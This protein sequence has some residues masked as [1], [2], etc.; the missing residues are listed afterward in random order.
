VGKG[1]KAAAITGLARH[2]LRAAAQYERSPADMLRVLNRA[3]LDQ[4]TDEEQ[5]CTVAVAQLHGDDLRIACGGHPLPLVLRRDGTVEP[6]G[7]PG[8]LIGVLEEPPLHDDVLTLGAGDTVVLY[9]DGITD[10]R[11]EHGR[12][13]TD[14][15]AALLAMLVGLPPAQIVERLD[16]AVSAYRTGAATDDS[17][18]VAFRLSGHS[19]R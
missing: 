17:A 5:F 7:R 4:F 1:A 3:M 11:G 9:T 13:G 2:T 18:V 8:A 6:I 15:L 16:R 14:R 10:A 12:F 19:A